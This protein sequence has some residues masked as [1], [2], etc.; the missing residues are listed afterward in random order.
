V[1]HHGG[2]SS[3]QVAAQR[4]ISFHTSKIRYYR[5]YHGPLLAA[6]LRAFLLIGYAGRLILEGAKWLV[7]HKR[8][9][10]KERVHAY[11][12]VIRSGLKES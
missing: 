7:G 9:M 5:R 1:I 6:S 4:D 8:A 2:K 3:E 11:W 12:Q 10:R